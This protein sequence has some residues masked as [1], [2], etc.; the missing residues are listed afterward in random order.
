MSS[1]R[2][3]LRHLGPVSYR[4]SPDPAFA[5]QTSIY[6]IVPPVPQRDGYCIATMFEREPILA[7]EK[8]FI[9]ETRATD[10]HR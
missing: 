3:L 6:Q 4:G 8:I 9:N 2:H 10:E 1:Q 7:Q 5:C